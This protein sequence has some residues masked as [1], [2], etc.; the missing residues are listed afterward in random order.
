M[1]LLLDIWLKIYHL[2]FDIK[3]KFHN[4]IYIYMNQKIEF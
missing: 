4:S 1:R 3:F 2:T